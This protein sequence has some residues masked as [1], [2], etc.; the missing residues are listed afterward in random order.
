MYIDYIGS[1]FIYIKCPTNIYFYK[2]II[3]TNRYKVTEYTSNVQVPAGSSPSLKNVI[4]IV[5]RVLRY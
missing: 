3:L 4:G 5:I 1:F 2:S